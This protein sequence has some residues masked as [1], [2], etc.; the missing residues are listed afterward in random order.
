MKMQGI[1][2]TQ[3]ILN[4]KNKIGG[5]TLPNFKICYKAIVF[6]IVRHWYKDCYIDPQNKIESAE[7]NLDIDG[8]VI[9]KKYAKTLKW[10]EMIVYSTKIL[11]QMDICMQKNEAE[12]P[13]SR[14]IQ[15]LT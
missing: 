9:F 5:L 8:Q 3:V 12:S 11:G 15:K 4:K 2:N 14:N 7:I 6:K 1:W 13:T 10:E